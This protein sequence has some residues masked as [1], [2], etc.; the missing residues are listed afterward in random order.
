VHIAN[1]LH[2]CIVIRNLFTCYTMEGVLTDYGMST[3]LDITLFRVRQ[4]RE[5]FAHIYSPG[6]HSIEREIHHIDST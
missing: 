4:E 1:D 2:C 3:V 5:L 6:S